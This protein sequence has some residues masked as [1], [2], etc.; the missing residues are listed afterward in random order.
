[1][2]SSTCRW[3]RYLPE[4]FEW[5]LLENGGKIEN[6]MYYIPRAKLTVPEVI[7]YEDFESRNLGGYTLFGGG[8]ALTAENIYEGVSSVKITAAKEESGLYKTVTGLTVGAQYRMV[9]YVRTAQDATAQIFARA[10]GDDGVYVTVYDQSEYYVRR[11][12]VFTATA[13]TMEIGVRVPIGSSVLIDHL[14]LTRVSETA[15]GTAKVAA[16]T[17]DG[18]Y[19]KTVSMTVTGT[20]GKEVLLKIGFANPTGAIVDASVMVN[21]TRFN[22]APLYMTGADA[23]ANKADHVYIPILLQNGENTVTLSIGDKTI[24]IRS[25]EIVTLTDRW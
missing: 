14:T 13:K 8:V 21:G 22:T 25:V 2:C 12:F 23:A 20:I 5:L 10:K 19:N 3:K 6:G 11:T 15:V 16:P 7:F 24:Y 4:N 9:C 18:A 1:M 17:A